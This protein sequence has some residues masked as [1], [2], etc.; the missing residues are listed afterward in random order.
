MGRD[1]AALAVGGETLA[2]R[3]ARRL[4]DVCGS[5]VV[6]D[7]GR[8]LLLPLPGFPSVP[9]GPG[10]GPAAGILGAAC[11]YP[12]HPLLV[13]ACDLPAIPAALLAELAAADG[14]ADWAVPR[15]QRGLEPLC[16][17]YRPAALAELAAAVGRGVAAPHRLAE[18]AGLKVRYLEGRSLRRFGA[19]EDLFLNLNT[20]LDV[21]RWI[22]TSG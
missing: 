8:G 22:S 11:A 18:A 2:A 14:A 20:P 6:A 15:W 1:K 21:E 12:G 17:L 3:A 9:D 5:V 4:L 7:G 10:Q 16:A 19:P 13:L